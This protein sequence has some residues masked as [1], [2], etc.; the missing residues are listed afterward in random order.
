MNGALHENGALHGN[1]ARHE[2]G[3]GPKRQERTADRA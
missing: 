1:R 2:N 3:A